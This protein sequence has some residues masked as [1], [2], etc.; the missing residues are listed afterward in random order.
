MTDIS[1]GPIDSVLEGYDKPYD[2]ETCDDLMLNNLFSKYGFADGNDPR[3]DAIHA[4]FS[5]RLKEHGYD[6][7]RIGSV[8]NRRVWSICVDGSWY[9]TELLPWG[10]EWALLGVVEGS[11]SGDENK[12]I[13]VPDDL[14]KAIMDFLPTA[15]EMMHPR[16]LPQ[17]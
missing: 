16:N 8:H 11:M 13:P 12:K 4:S 5:T 3:A 6:N 10:G 15:Y 17:R 9:T 14:K 2:S 1:D 7:E